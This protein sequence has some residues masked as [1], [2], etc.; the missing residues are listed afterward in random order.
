M[1]ELIEKLDEHCSFAL[2]VDS[3]EHKNKII[4]DM[5]LS[6]PSKNECLDWNGEERVQDVYGSQ[7]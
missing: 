6:S 4:R 1:D 3:G 7:V 5:P 2:T